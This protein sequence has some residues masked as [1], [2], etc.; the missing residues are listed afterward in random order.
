MND[1]FHLPKSARWLLLPVLL[2]SF[3]IRHSSF[4]Q[5]P[6]PALDLPG[7]TVVVYN[8]DFSQSRELAEYYAEKRGISKDRL[9]GLDLPLED[10]ISR[11]QFE[12]LIRKP[13]F[14]IF[15]RRGWSEKSFDTKIMVDGAE[16]PAPT[17]GIDNFKNRIVSMPF[18]MATC[19]IAFEVPVWVII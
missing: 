11:E 8:P 16:R 10:S 18:W 4:S 1:T 14:E 15:V 2:S 9:I 3:V 19:L 5:E 13:L 7:E 12:K 17:H 6:E